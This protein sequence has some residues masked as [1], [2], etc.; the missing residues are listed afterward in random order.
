MMLVQQR[1]IEDLLQRFR[2]I[3]CNTSPSPCDPVQKLS[4]AVSS[5]TAEEEDKMKK[6]AF[7]QLIDGLQFLTKSTS[8]DTAYDANSMSTFSDNPR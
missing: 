5:Q 2:M 3:S 1:Y 8:P 6:V 4:K 7:R